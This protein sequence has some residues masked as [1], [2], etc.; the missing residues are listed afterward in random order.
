MF[1]RLCVHSLSAFLETNKFLKWF[2]PL[3]LEVDWK[4]YL[5]QEANI[6]FLCRI[7]LE[8]CHEYMSDVGHCVARGNQRIVD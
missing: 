6:L 2:L 4:K 7:L 5:E 1:M 8:G 3:Y